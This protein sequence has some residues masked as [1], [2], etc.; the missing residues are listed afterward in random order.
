VQVG[1]EVPV[2]VLQELQALL[3]L[4]FQSL[5]L[6]RIMQAAAV[7]VVGFQLQQAV[8]AVQAVVVR[9]VDPA[10]VLLEQQELQT[11]VAVAVPGLQLLVAQLRLA[12]PVAL[13]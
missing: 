1:K 11:Q 7:A 8:Q 13:E 3:V 9:V 12:V 4:L 5:E 6:L 10:V 2:A